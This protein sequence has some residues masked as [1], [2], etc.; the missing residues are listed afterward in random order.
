M[1]KVVIIIVNYNKYEDTIVCVESLLNIYNIHLANIIIVDNCSTND[2]YSILK[3]R[4]IDSKITILYADENKGYCA[5]NNIGIVYAKQNINP[6]YYWILNPDTIVDNMAMTALI[7]FAEDHIE[8]GI[9]GSRL[10]Y[11]PDMDRLQ[12]LGG[13]YITIDKLGIISL[14]QI[15]NGDSVT[16]KLPEYIELE[17]LVGASLFI[18]KE[19]IEI[20]GLMDESYFMY[21]DE[22][23]YCLRAKQNGWKLYGVSTSVIY[24][25][26]GWREQKQKC[27]SQYYAVRNRL[28]LIHRY[29]PKHLFVNTLFNFY[30]S[31]RLL[32]RIMLLRRNSMIMSW[33]TLKG[34]IDF[35]LQ[36]KGKVI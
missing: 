26:E 25:K 19:V 24:H 5:G 14:T 8:A 10:I 4:F 3:E 29:Y 16:K 28:F 34:I 36:K 35:F 20:I 32:C 27:W 22:S 30:I 31:F 23:E 18:K 6:D 2:S 1:K 15:F 13:G 9:I 11:Y 7:E 21:F 33:Y 12:A 17:S